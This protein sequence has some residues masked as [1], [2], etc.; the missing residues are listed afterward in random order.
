[1]GVSS[2]VAAVV[3]LFGPTDLRPISDP[4]YRGNYEEIFGEAVFSEDAMWAFSP[5]AY[6]SVDAPPFLIFHGGADETVMPHH[7]VDL[8]AALTDAGVP[9]EL[10]IVSGGGHSNA[11]FNE[12]CVSGFGRVDGNP[13]GIPGRASRDGL[14]SI[15]SRGFRFPLR[16]ASTPFGCS[17]SLQGL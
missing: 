17:A 13:A 16:C 3:D 7:S 14:N 4:R 11:L 1:M 9:V 12:G 5:L 10:V 8:Q 6:M 2:E 15:L